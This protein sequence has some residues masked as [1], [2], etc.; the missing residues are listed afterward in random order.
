MW[1]VAVTNA[2]NFIDNMDGIAA[3]VATASA[4]GIAAIA[5]YNG[6]YLVTSLA[7]ATA[8]AALGFL[9]YN[10]PPAK[11]F[12]GDAG[13]CSLGFM[14]AALILK[15]DLPVGPSAPRVLSTVLLAGVPLFD[16]SVV[17]IARLRDRTDRSGA[18]ARTTHRTAWP[19]PVVPAAGCC[20]TRSRRSSCVLSSPTRCTGS[21]RP[22]CSAWVCAV[23][24]VWLVLLGIFLRMPGLTMAVDPLLA[25][26][27]SGASG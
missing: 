7:L 10:I 24:V 19:P 6:D 15:L 23:G 5:G 14:V 13:R 17:V 4:L 1:V 16:L 12:L 3:G 25:D 21:R 18:A 2:F 20:C 8:G 9:R 26:D 22:S 11:I 27:G